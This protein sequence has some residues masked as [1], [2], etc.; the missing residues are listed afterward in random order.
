M[1]GICLQQMEIL[2][3][4]LCRHVFKFVLNRPITWFDLAFYDPAMFD[5]LRAIVYNDAE[6]SAHNP[7]F[8]ESLHLTFAVDISPE[9]VF[10]YYS[11]NKKFAVRIH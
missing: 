4:F 9:E 7:E 2:P 1:I 3:L 10:Y 6:D 5:S 11:C 8:Y